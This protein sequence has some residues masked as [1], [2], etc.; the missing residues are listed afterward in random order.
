M[1]LAQLKKNYPFPLKH[2]SFS[3]DGNKIWKTSDA[4]IFTQGFELA[5]DA[6]KIIDFNNDKYRINISSGKIKK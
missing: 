3:M 4:D 6:I 1:N 2:K 5:S